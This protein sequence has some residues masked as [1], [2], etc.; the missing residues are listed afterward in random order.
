MRIACLH[1][2]DS[3][4][5]IFDAAADALG[6]TPDTLSHHAR[7]DLLA[8]AMQAGTL[9]PALQ[10]QTH[11]ALLELAQT[12]DL[13]LLTCSTLGPAA[14]T[15]N[16]VSSV[17]VWRVDEALAT[18][19]MSRAGKTRVLYA[20]DTTLTPTQE[21]FERVKRHPKAD[22]EFQRVDNAWDF[23][24]AG[25]SAAYLQRIAAAADEAFQQGIERVALAQA[26]MSGAVELTQF[27]AP[28]SSPRC[29]LRDAIAFL[30]TSAA[31]QNL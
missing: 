6:I 25:N 4:I 16:D 28:L 26:S 30:R 10:Q 11:D 5:A 12:A 13:V 14:A 23:F 21:V 8:A 22:V 9:T 2:A 1:T 19:A 18:K 24:M 20:A 7:P 31:Q 17:P 29:A 27:G 3:N 15:A